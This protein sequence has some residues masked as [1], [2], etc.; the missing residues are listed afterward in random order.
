MS[1]IG[2][3]LHGVRDCAKVQP[4]CRVVFR[5]RGR[6]RWPLA[7][8]F[9]GFGLGLSVSTYRDGRTGGARGRS[10]RRAPRSDPV[11]RTTACG[12]WGATRGVPQGSRRPEREPPPD[13]GSCSAPGDQCQHVQPR[14]PPRNAGYVTALVQRSSRPWW[15]SQSSTVAKNESGSSSQG[16]WPL[17]SRITTSA[18]F[19]RDAIRSDC[20][21]AVNAS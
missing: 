13:L 15:C 1:D 9:V 19:S 3:E 5:R 21:H 20:G 6:C 18:S 17:R 11:R 16:K 12:P 2:S 4:S 14:D 8:A 7:R 10:S